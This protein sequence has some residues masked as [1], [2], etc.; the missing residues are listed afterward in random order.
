M[1]NSLIYR[2]RLSY[3]EEEG[4]MSTKTLTPSSDVFAALPW[5]DQRELFNISTVF[6]LLD[7]QK[8]LALA[9]ENVRRF[10]AQYGTTLDMLESK[11]LPEDAGYEMHEDY[12]EWHYWARVREKTQDTLD[13]LMIV[14]KGHKLER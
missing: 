2:I 3:S 11:G 9:Q 7:L 10:E 14:S 4:K 13:V 1:T 6:R 8:R 5:E 12:I